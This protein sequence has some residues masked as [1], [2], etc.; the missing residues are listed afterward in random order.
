M[1]TPAPQP[2]TGTVVVDTSGS[3]NLLVRV[4][5]FLLV[6]WWATFFLTTAAVLLALTVVG[7]P[8]SIYLMNRIPAAMTLKLGKQALH[9][10]TGEDGRQ[11]LAVVRPQQRPFWQRAVWYVLVG[12][13]ATTLWLYLAWFACLTILGLPLG[14]WMYG[15]TGKL[16]TLKR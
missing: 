16:L 9:I 1:T 8:G 12:W 2:A 14:F 6:G 10:T 15:A 3:P 11:T 5:W 13:L 4:A 7:I